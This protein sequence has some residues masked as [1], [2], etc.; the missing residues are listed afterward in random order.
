MN[1]G[2]SSSSS[3]SS[4]AGVGVFGLLG[5]L[6]IG[7]KLTGF[8]DWDWV[9]VLAPFWGGMAFALSILIIG[10]AFAL[11]FFVIAWALDR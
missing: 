2:S 3:S 9:W 7:L 5:V 11:A 6:F 1:E 4:S 8:V 10:G